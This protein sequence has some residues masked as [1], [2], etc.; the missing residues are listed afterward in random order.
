SGR[1][2]L[3]DGVDWDCGCWGG[4]AGGGDGVLAWGGCWEGCAAGLGC[5]DGFLPA[6][7]CCDSGSGGITSSGWCGG[8]AAGGGCAGRFGSSAVGNA[9]GVTF[10]NGGACFTSGSS[11]GVLSRC[12]NCGMGAPPRRRVASM[13][14]ILALTST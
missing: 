9:G 3:S 6:A 14:A 7:G 1:C 2:G 13:A 12:F 11:T 8:L 4:G 5:C 10:S